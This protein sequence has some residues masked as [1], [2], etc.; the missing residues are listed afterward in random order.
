MIGPETVFCGWCMDPFEPDE[1]S[2][3][4]EPF[5]SNECQDKAGEQYDRELRMQSEGPFFTTRSPFRK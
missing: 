2:D 4:E 1:S 5:C 3:T